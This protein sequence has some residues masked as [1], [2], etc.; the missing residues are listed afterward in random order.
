[1][2]E[3]IGDVVAPIELILPVKVSKTIIKPS[4]AMFISGAKIWFSPD[5]SSV[6]VVTSV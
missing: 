5:G 1:M 6:E 2:V 3:I 4:G